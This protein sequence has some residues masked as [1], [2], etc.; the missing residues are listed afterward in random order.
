MITCT[1]VP[2]RKA[3]KAGF[4]SMRDN[5]SKS[6]FSKYNPDR[7]ISRIIVAKAKNY[8]F[9]NSFNIN[10]LTSGVTGES[11]RIMDT[12]YPIIGADLPVDSVVIGRSPMA[13]E[14]TGNRSPRTLI[15]RSLINH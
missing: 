14:S 13:M 9:E 2:K 10:V 6:P 12:K 8:S 3:M 5:F 15:R 1:T 7:R 4:E 11:A